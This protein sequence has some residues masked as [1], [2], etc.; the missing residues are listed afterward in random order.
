MVQ[1]VKDVVAMMFR[2]H[3]GF[4]VRLPR[5]RIA[6]MRLKTMTS[7]RS[8]SGTI[9]PAKETAPAPGLVALGPFHL[10]ERLRLT[11][12]NFHF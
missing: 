1:R 10:I 3:P 7:C 5:G 11:N 9:T 8:S 2:T 6:A 12:L 4:D